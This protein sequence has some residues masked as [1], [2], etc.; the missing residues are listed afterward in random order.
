MKLIQ[1]KYRNN[2]FNISDPDPEA[3]WRTTWNLRQAPGKLHEK[4][5]RQ[6]I[7]IAKIG[8]NRLAL[9]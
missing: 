2:I 3:K 5:Y 1:R 9:A 8:C 4:L 6:T 7:G